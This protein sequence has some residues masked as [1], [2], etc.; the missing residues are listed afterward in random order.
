LRADKLWDT[1]LARITHSDYGSLA[2]N[3]MINST[4]GGGYLAGKKMTLM[5]YELEILNSH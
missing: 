1:L 3:G 2:K 4:I 5:L